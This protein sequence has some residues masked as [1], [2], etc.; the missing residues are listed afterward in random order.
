[1]SDHPSH[2]NTAASG[3]FSKS[4]PT[5]NRFARSARPQAPTAPAPIDAPAPSTVQD[6]DDRRIFT[7]TLD[8]IV[9]D[10]QVSVLFTCL[11]ADISELTDE[12][13]MRL[14]LGLAARAAINFGFDP[15]HPVA[16]TILDPASS[17]RLTRYARTVFRQ[18]DDLRVWREWR[19]AR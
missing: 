15:D 13:V 9:G 2:A 14:G 12:L 8:E 11:A 6:V 10:E 16:L 18:E 17:A 1:M 7:A 4:V 19:R 5:P 3:G